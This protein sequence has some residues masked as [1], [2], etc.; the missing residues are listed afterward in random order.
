MKNTILKVLFVGMVAFSCS[1]R[2]D[3]PRVEPTDVTIQVTYND[4]FD[5]KSASGTNVVIRNTT[6]QQTFEGQTSSDGSILFEAVPS[7][8]YDITASITMDSDEFFAFAGYLSEGDE[9][10]FNANQTGVPIN[11][12]ASSFTLEL[13]SGRLGNLVFKQI[14]IAGSDRV[15]GAQFR[16]QFIEIH[17][18][19]TEVQYMDGLYIMGVVSKLNNSI[20]EFTQADGQWDWTK[21]V[22][23][24]ATGDPNND[25]VYSKWLYQF[26]GSGN[27]YP[28]EPGKSIILASTAINHKTPFEG[29]DGNTVSVNNP[30][31]TVDLSNADFEVYL[32]N[33]VDRPLPSDV[34]NTSVPNMINHFWQGTD[35]IMDNRGREAIVLFATEDDI[36]TFPRYATPN[37]QNITNNTV[38]R[39]QIPKSLI[40]DGVEGQESPTNQVPK[41]LPTDIDAGF[42][43]VPGGAWS[44]E[45]GIR[46]TANT[47]GDRKVL[48]DSNNSEND[49]IGKK[50][51]PRGYAD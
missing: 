51:N 32:G 41:M 16:D 19:S 13:V 25:Y 18:N 36:S 28:V 15:D 6:S 43:Y 8:I 21:S 45:A 10:V 42:F 37:S 2:D 48:K 27:Q 44:S 29:N 46:M 5:Q 33:D 1:E 24:N 38:M 3:T 20:T 31:L 39:Y 26:P 22:G 12:G 47:F 17:N 49:L 40:I 23:M 34:D 35:L 9:V 14:Y 30:E 50:A 4:D 7:G 11:S